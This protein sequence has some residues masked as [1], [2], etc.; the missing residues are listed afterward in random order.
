MR[1]NTQATRKSVWNGKEATSWM[2]L[3]A[4]SPT[5]GLT[6]SSAVDTIHLRGVDIQRFEQRLGAVDANLMS[7]VAAAIALVVEYD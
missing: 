6:K 5:N 1:T 2:R 7:E 4:P 3:L